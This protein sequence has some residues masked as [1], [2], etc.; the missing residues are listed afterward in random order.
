MLHVYW[1]RLLSSLNT[2]FLYIVLIIV[3]YYVTAKLYLLFRLNEFCFFLVDDIIL[4]KSFFL[5]GLLPS[6]DLPLNSFF[7]SFN[8]KSIFS[9]FIS[10]D[11][12]L[13]FKTSPKRYFL[14]ESV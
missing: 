9:S 2:F 1:L 5:L 7:F 13:T 8:V 14:P 3:T 4:A 12:S 11:K 6:F 10:T